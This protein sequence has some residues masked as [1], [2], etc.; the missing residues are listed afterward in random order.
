M[1]TSPLPTHLARLLECIECL[2]RFGE[3]QLQLIII[4]E[5]CEDRIG[6][7]GVNKHF[8]CV[9]VLTEPAQPGTQNLS[10]RSI[11]TVSARL[12][13]VPGQVVSYRLLPLS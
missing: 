9:P 3:P 1:P 7:K 12:G 5:T 11:W 4:M 8:Y 13:P 10:L 6:T 2:G